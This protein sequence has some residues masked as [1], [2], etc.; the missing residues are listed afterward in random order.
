MAKSIREVIMGIEQV[1]AVIAATVVPQT[2][3]VSPADVAVAPL[4]QNVVVPD[5]D[6]VTQRRWSGSEIKLAGN[7]TAG[8]VQTYDFQ[9]K[10]NDSN[11]DSND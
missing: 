8:S 6:F 2:A 5:Y 9:G 10:P 4:V 3:G 7:Y 11:M 1:I